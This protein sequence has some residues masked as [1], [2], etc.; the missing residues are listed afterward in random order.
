MAQVR[1][2]QEKIK[3]ARREEE[4][5]LMQRLRAEQ[6]AEIQKN[7]AKVLENKERLARWKAEN[8]KNMAMRQR[9]KAEQHKK[10]ILEVEEA[11]RVLEVK[12]K[13][14][15]ADFIALKK[16][17][18]MRDAIALEQVRFPRPSSAWLSVRSTPLI[19]ELIAV[20]DGAIVTSVSKR[21]SLQ[22]KTNA[23]F[24]AEDEQR[25]IREQ[26]KLKAKA[27]A[28]HQEKVGA[29]LTAPPGGPA[30]AR[31]QPLRTVPLFPTLPSSP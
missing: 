6:I 15:E 29:A 18:E 26:E 27:E 23:E 17:M 12:E 2:R 8:D 28:E 31:E 21:V 10:E 25:M 11:R 24:L 13:K 1:E 16:K 19:P 20:Y 4:Q 14:R 5:A 22:G 9:L 30:A 3:A 7:K